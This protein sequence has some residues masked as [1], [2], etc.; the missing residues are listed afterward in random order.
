[1]EIQGEKAK[2]GSAPGVRTQHT[3]KL[4]MVKELEKTFIKFNS[5]K[6]DDLVRGRKSLDKLVRSPSRLKEV[7][8]ALTHFGTPRSSQDNIQV[9]KA[10]APRPSAE[11]NGSGIA[12]E[13]ARSPRETGKMDTYLLKLASR[14]PRRDD[15]AGR[16]TGKLS[17]TGRSLTGRHVMDQFM[18]N[19]LSYYRD[20]KSIEKL[21][22]MMHDP[23]DQHPAQSQQSRRSQQSETYESVLEDLQ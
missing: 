10:K 21:R 1:M 3:A 6:K 4:N 7:T 5:P 20:L 19:F 11:S 12:S 16:D 8:S 18:Q 15:R 23:E 9:E 2:I 13:A 14:S 22:N 17:A